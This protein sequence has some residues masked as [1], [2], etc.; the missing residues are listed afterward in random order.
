MCKYAWTYNIDILLTSINQSSIPLSNHLARIFQA[1]HQQEG[2]LIRA[3]IPNVMSCDDEWETHGIDFRK[4]A[5]TYLDMIFTWPSLQK[6]KHF[7]V[8]RNTCMKTYNLMIALFVCEYDVF[9]VDNILTVDEC[10]KH[11]FV[12]FCMTR[13][14]L[15]GVENRICWSTHWPVELWIKLCVLRCESPCKMSPATP[16][17]LNVLR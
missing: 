3:S 15:H 4:A 16:C 17:R 8:V 10:K 6:Q 1:C 14:V 9:T 13:R 2:P 12:H 7:S 11:I 5:L